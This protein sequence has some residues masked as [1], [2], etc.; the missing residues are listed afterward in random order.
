MA[1]TT[2]DTEAQFLG[3]IN[4]K[5]EIVTAVNLNDWSSHT[6]QIRTNFNHTPPRQI[7]WWKIVD[8]REKEINQPQLH[9]DRK[10]GQLPLNFKTG[11]WRNFVFT[12]SWNSLYCFQQFSLFSCMNLPTE[13]TT[14]PTLHIGWIATQVSRSQSKYYGRQFRLQ[15]RLFCWGRSFTFISRL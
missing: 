13:W 4:I 14:F 1:I 11:F 6:N 5:Y 2:T 12:W 10:R 7:L 3:I 15:V 8:R 9:F